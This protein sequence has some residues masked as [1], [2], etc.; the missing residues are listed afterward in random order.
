[1]LKSK[2]GGK[3]FKKAASK[4]VTS[5]PENHFKMY[6]KGFLSLVFKYNIKLPYRH[7]TVASQILSE[8][9]KSEKVMPN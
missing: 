1:M 4:N 9:R 7:R 2:G 5:M 3:K 8:E 6:Q